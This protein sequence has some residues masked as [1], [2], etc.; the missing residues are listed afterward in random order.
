MG[1]LAF[2]SPDVNRR[3]E[4]PH[5]YFYELD[6]ELPQLRPITKTHY[7]S[8]REKRSLIELLFYPFIIQEDSHTN[9]QFPKGKLAPAEL[10]RNIIK[11][12][13][14]KRLFIG[15]VNYFLNTKVMQNKPHVI[16]CKS[17]NNYYRT[18]N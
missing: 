5:F 15:Q 9:Y 8:F 2:Y 3:V 1:I 14:V 6:V 12:S 18:G 17:Y 7:S 4:K 10:L 11:C 16:T 13:L